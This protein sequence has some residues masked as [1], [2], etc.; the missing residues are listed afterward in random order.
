MKK[1]QST[2]YEMK[3]ILDGHVIRFEIGKERITKL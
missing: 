2:V 1:L 3:Y